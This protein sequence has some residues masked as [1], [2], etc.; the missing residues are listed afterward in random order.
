[1]GVQISEIIPKKE[2][3]LIDLKGKIIAIDAMNTLYQ[4]LTT[5]RQIDGTPLKDNKGNITS[6]L[7]GLFYR[8][9]NLLTLGIKPIYVFDGKP[10]ELKNEEL[11]RRKDLKQKAEKKYEEAKQNQ[12]IPSMRKYSQQ[13]V[14]IDQKILDE[15]KEFLKAL[16]IPVI[17]SQGEGEG[18]AAHLVASNAAWASA[19]QDYDSLLYGTPKLIRNLTLSR[20][21]KSSNGQ[22]IET[23]IE[24]IDF[25]NLLNHLQIN[26]DQLI[27]LGILVGTDFNP[28]GIKGIGQMK[29]LEIVR[30]YQYPI[31]IFEHIETNKKY[32]IDFDWQEI[33]QEFKRYTQPNLIQIKFEKPNKNKVKEMLLKHDFSEDRINSGLEKLEIAEEGKKQKDLG[34][35]F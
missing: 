13:F 29:A 25:E 30:K 20:K 35:F 3:R 15:S 1:M 17:E 33:F 31:K 7:S 22:Y 24:L 4:F 19:S 5:I 8:N 18:E 11:K 23:S 12:D 34:D 21:K 27:C 28:G 9:I 32:T 2:I 26:R 16:G 6:H 10:P 14:K